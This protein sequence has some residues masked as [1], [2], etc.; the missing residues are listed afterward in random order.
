MASSTYQK[1][2]TYLAMEGK[3]LY[4]SYHELKDWFEQ[5]MQGP[6]KVRRQW[7][8]GFKNYIAIVEDF[9][10]AESNLKT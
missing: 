1:E 5:I 9:P 7:K 10:K 4:S 6:V 3:L 8:N 2:Q